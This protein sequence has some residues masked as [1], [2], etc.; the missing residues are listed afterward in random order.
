M[1]SRWLLL[2]ACLAACAEEP[3]PGGEPVEIGW[4]ALGISA[5]VLVAERRGI[6]RAHGLDVVLKRYE[7][8]QPLVEEVADGRIACGGY[9]AI[10]IVATAIARGGSPPELATA[11]IEDEAHPISRLLARPASPI[12]GPADLAGRRVGILPT[13]AYRRWLDVVV[14]HAHADPAEVEVVPLAPSQQVAA[15]AEGGVDA[16]FTNDPMATAALTSG[17]G[18]LAGPAAP[19]PDA[20]GGEVLFGSFLIGADFA[21]DRPD[22]AA[23]VVSALDEAIAALDADPGL[24][25]LVFAAEVRASERASLARQAPRRW[26]PSPAADQARLDAEVAAEVRLGILPAPVPLRVHPPSEPER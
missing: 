17:A 10:P 19:V 23:R 21:R 12:R 24:A 20:L 16:L 11:L 25:A 9:A 26:I 15:L 13:I 2:A 4:S 18:V 5:P 14:R 22:A 3:R 1:T 6:F 8:A 7:T